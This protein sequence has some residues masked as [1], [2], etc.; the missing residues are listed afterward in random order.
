MTLSI[1][2]F[3]ISDY[4]E[5][6]NRQRLYFESL[7]EL[8]KSNKP[9]AEEYLLIGEH[10]PVY[11]IGVH[12]HVENLLADESALKNMGAEVIRIERGGDITFHGPGQLIAYPIIDLEMHNLGI[13]DYMYLLE[14]SVILLLQSF[15]LTAT[16]IS[17]ATGVWM[18]KDTPHERKICAM[19]VKCSRFITMHGLALNVSTN[20]KFFEAI[21]PCGF[22]DKGVTSMQ[23]E[24]G[25]SP[26]MNEVKSRFSKIFENLIH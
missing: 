3:G 26:D 24:L 20:L 15:G 16:R 19:G 25:Y 21:N 6:W 4:R 8:K 22:I 10:N 14:E 1:T 2:D 12:G 18:G 11:T 23:Q 9:V 17:G 7:I 5:I 13:K